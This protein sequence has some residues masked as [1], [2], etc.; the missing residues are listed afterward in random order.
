MQM[1]FDFKNGEAYRVDGAGYRTIA[2]QLGVK[3]RLIRR[4]M[5][6][7][8]C[9]LRPTLYFD[10]EEKYLKNGRPS[11][12][13][14]VDALIRHRKDFNRFCM[15]GILQE[16][17]LKKGSGLDPDKLYKIHKQK[18]DRQNDLIDSWIDWDGEIDVYKEIGTDKELE[19]IKKIS[20]TD[21]QE[22]IEKAKETKDVDD[23]ESDDPGENVYGAMLESQVITP[24]AW[25]I[26]KVWGEYKLPGIHLPADMWDRY[27]SIYEKKL[28][29]G[30]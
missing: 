9:F 23:E 11:I 10:F 26:E 17:E 25:Y 24:P 14:L 20:K 12:K 19:E 16:Y 2:K 3:D 6:Q 29:R 21:P 7:S 1:L 15:D 8:S 28:I 4:I 27:L 18:L 13:E 5:E 30:R 22:I